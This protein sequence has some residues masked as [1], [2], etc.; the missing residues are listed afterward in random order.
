MGASICT[1]LTPSGD[2][3]LVYTPNRAADYSGWWWCR[4]TGQGS[5]TTNK[6]EYTLSQGGKSVFFFMCI[7]C[8]DV[9]AQYRTAGAQIMWRNAEQR[10]GSKSR[11]SQSGVSRFDLNWQHDTEEVFFR[12]TLLFFK[13][14][15]WA[16]VAV[17]L[18][19]F[20]LRPTLIWA[21][22]Q[23]ALI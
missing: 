11:K 12:N 7:L 23:L 15:F 14:F 8:V 4:L 21:R 2:K 18:W 16:Y 19:F 13:I 20:H 9:S 5:R 3:V 17:F 22:T 1:G 6:G 10:A